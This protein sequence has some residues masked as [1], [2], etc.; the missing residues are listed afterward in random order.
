MLMKIILVS[1]FILFGFYLLKFQNNIDEVKIK[2]TT[3]HFRGDDDGDFFFTDITSIGNY[4]DGKKHGTWIFYDD[5]GNVDRI[6]KY[7]DGDLKK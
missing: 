6:V 4:Q 3:M 1:S 7:E 2:Q 5:N